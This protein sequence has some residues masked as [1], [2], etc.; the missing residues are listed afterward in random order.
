MV[1]ATKTTTVTATGAASTV[2]VT[3]AGGTSGLSGT[4]QIG[5]LSDLSDGLSS[6]GLR[7]QAYSQQ[8]TTD[9]NTWLGTTQW[10]GKVTFKADVVDYKGDLTT[11]DTDLK[12]LASSGVTVAVG[13]LS[14]GVVGAIYKDAQS[15]N[16]VLISP[17]STSP[18][19]YGV[20]PY[21]YRTAPNDVFQGQADA[22]EAASQG[23]KGLIIVYRDDTYG[24]GLFNYT[25]ADFSKL[26]GTT[27]DAI[28]YSTTLSGQ[29]AFS[30]IATTINTDYQALTAKYGA[31][32]VAIDAISFEEVGY[33]LKAVQASYPSLITTAQPWYGTDGEQ[34]DTALTNSTYGS[35]MQSTRMVASV[36]GYTNT[37]KTISVCNDFKNQPSLSCDSYALGAYD[38]TWLAALSILDCGANNG[39]C[40][41]KVLPSIA[42]SYFGVTGWTSLT[43]PTGV[44]GDRQGGDFQLWCVQNKPSAGLNWY[45]CGD[46]SSTTNTVSW[47][48]GQ[49]PST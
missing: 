24:Y 12:S 46:W 14:S 9:I 29:Q 15:L 39:A 20:S 2:T 36:F 23:V 19:Y 3:G 10:A 18:A 34:G 35:L 4:I 7:V 38:D 43:S 8:A 16:V 44:G 6:E 41:S 21:L 11:A 48:P 26:S 5:V 30:S 42:N 22:T 33:L 49:Q 17:S 13:P 45:F 28:P 40:V 31:G 47:L 1:T 37:T 32:A 27:V 25:S